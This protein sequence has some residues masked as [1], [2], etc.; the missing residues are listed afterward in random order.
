MAENVDHSSQGKIAL[1]TPEAPPMV[2]TPSP[3]I[4]TRGDQE[5]ANQQSHN[6]LAIDIN[7][8]Q[9]VEESQSLN[10]DTDYGG[11]LDS[12]E[13]QM[14]EED[15]VPSIMTEQNLQPIQSNPAAESLKD[16]ENQQQDMSVEIDQ[17]V[18]QPGASAKEEDIPA[19]EPSIGEACALVDENAEV[20]EAKI[21]KQKE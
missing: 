7:D 10:C 3:M 8:S 21:E 18:E 11:E 15:K 12:Y 4:D 17:P 9:P 6:Q 13:M 20:A 2:Q 14:L 5:M 19:A 16:D 1:Q